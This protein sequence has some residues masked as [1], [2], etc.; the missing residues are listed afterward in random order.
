[1]LQ[2]SDK[3]RA[4]DFLPKSNPNQKCVKDVGVWGWKGVPLRC[5]TTSGKL[6]TFGGRYQAFFVH[7]IHQ[8]WISTFSITKQWQVWGCC[9]LLWRANAL[10][11][12]AVL[13][14]AEANTKGVRYKIRKWRQKTVFPRITMKIRKTS[15]QPKQEESNDNKIIKTS[16]E[17]EQRKVT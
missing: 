7:K 14:Q 15:P 9:S 8:K 17:Q 13:W 2:K 11:P 4:G 16:S 3:T 5:L 12:T 6:K 1:M 10:C